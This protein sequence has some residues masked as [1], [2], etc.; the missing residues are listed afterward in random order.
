M[1][2]FS[3][4]VLKQLNGP[5]VRMTPLVYFDFRSGG[6]GVWPGSGKLI[7][8]GVTYYGLSGLGTLSQVNSGPGGNVE[9]L[10]LTLA[11]TPE[12]VSKMKADT[13]E[14]ID[15]ECI[16]KFQFFDVR[17]FDENG[18]YVSWNLIDE[19]FEFFWGR[20][21]P[22][23]LNREPNKVG[24]VA[25]RTISVVAQNALIN[26]SRAKYSYFSHRD[27]LAR[28]GGTDNIFIRASQMASTTVR[29]P[30]F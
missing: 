19:P 7:V 11:A 12:A 4:L 18:D 5:T 22:L 10:T 8:S 30:H 9:E 13:E 15:R 25:T 3:D 21:G 20:M 16:A 23:T 17:E 6:L 24:E 26:R 28:T 29:W 14:S 2:A 27:Q 1:A